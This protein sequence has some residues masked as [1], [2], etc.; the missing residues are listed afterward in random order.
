[1]RDL[2]KVDS[3]EIPC[4]YLSVQTWHSRQ[5]KLLPENCLFGDT[6]SGGLRTVSG[7]PW[8]CD[9]L[10]C[11]TNQ[12]RTKLLS[13]CESLTPSTD[14]AHS[15]NALQVCR[16]K[17]RA[18]TPSVCLIGLSIL[19]PGPSKDSTTLELPGGSHI[20]K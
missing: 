7:C 3:V 13:S 6:V 11:K 9:L 1:M 19:F 8:D 20:R 10:D 2:G 18:K 5:S 16:E 4:Q 14:L 15:I 17:V 12:H